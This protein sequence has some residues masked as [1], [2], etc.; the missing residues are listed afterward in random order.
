MTKDDDSLRRDVALFRYGLI[1]DLLVQPAGSHEIVAGLR[2][3]AARDHVI[4]GT[5]RTRV[6]E[7]TMRDWMR[8]YRSGGFDALFPKRRRDDGKPRRLAVEASEPTLSGRTRVQRPQP[9]T[10]PGG[11]RRPRGRAPAALDRSPP[12]VPRRTDGE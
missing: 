2:D 5:N 1:A 11:R 10:G 3:R 4:P 8:L 12:P 6:G 9:S 7:Q